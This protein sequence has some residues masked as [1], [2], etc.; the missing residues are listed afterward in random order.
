[1]IFCRYQFLL[2]FLVVFEH[3]S[4]KLKENAAV[5]RCENKI[6]NHTL[7]EAQD[8]NAVAYQKSNAFPLPVTRAVHEFAFEMFR[9]A[10]EQPN[11]RKNIIF[12][13]LSMY[14]IFSALLPG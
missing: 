1:M 13:P 3:E 11:S 10:I 6:I 7:L 12:S 9:K 8:G 2:F 4:G 14:S 5:I